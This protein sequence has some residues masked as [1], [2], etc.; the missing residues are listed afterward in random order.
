M[1]SLQEDPALGPSSPAIL[2]ALLLAMVGCG[3]A[4]RDDRARRVQTAS[5]SAATRRR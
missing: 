4:Q 1:F 2:V 3:A 5:A